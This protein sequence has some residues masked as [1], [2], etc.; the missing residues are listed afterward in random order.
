[1]KLATLPPDSLAS[2]ETNFEFEAKKS[3]RSKNLLSHPLLTNPLLS[4]RPIRTLLASLFLGMLQLTAVATPLYAQQVKLP[5]DVFGD[6]IDNTRIYR[7]L[8]SR[9]IALVAEQPEDAVELLST[10]LEEATRSTTLDRSTLKADRPKGREHVYRH[11]VMSSVYLGEL[12]NCG[13][14]DKT[15]ASFSGGVVISEDGLVLTNYHVLGPS[16]KKKREGHM[17][18]TYDGK[19]FRIEKILAAD[20]NA[21][22]ALIQLK[23]D[24]HR[25]HAAPIAKQRPAPMDTV[26][27]ISNPSGEF[28]VMTQGEVSRYAQTRGTRGRSGE[29]YWME[30]TADFGGGSS[31]SGIF[32]AQGEVVGLVSRLRPLMRAASSP[33]IE[34]KG[35]S[36]RSRGAFVEMLLRKCVPLKAINDCFDK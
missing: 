5:F 20:K 28:F 27:L 18:M 2:N 13:R 12:Y 26:R 15:H 7:H 21:D 35:E 24:G 1:M 29:G 14:C 16:K 32:N 3:M 30:I 19:C 6:S 22:I 11:M 34:D 31:G 25:F 17:A 9:A 36:S 33:A 4:Y 23:A 8:E 10:Q